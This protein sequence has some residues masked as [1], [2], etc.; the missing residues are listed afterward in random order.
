M[1]KSRPSSLTSLIPHVIDIQS[2]FVQMSPKL[3]EEYKRVDI[4]LATNGIP[5]D[6]YGSHGGIILQCLCKHCLYWKAFQYG[7]M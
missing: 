2:S 4:I 7:L 5:T 3:K 1:N 6:D